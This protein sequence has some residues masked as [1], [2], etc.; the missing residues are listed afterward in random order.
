MWE[1]VRAS[2]LSE[3]IWSAPEQQSAD[4]LEVKSFHNDWLELLFC[5]ISIDLKFLKSH[6]TGAASCTNRDENIN[7]NISCNLCRAEN[8]IEYQQLLIL[9][10][11]TEVVATQ[12]VYEILKVENTII[13]H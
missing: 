10:H 3:C 12:I 11:K 1:Y 9:P 5:E 7:L 13:D 8:A 4:R 2:S 6:L